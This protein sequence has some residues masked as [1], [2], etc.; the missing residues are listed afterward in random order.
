MQ[1]TRRRV[2]TTDPTVCEFGGIEIELLDAGDPDAPVIVLCHGWPE[3]SH[4]WRHQIE[5]L[6]AAGWRVLV[7]D[8]RGY[9]ASSAPKLVDAY[10]TDRL[11]ADLVALL[12]DVGASQAVFVGHDWGALVVWDLARFHPDRV[13]AVV[14][15][16]VPYTPWMQRPTDQFREQFGDRFFYMLYFQEPDLAER[17]LE[18][19][20]E[21]SLLTILWGGDGS[22][23]RSAPDPS[24]LPPMEGTGLLDAWTGGVR[25]PDGRPPWLLETDLDHY[26]EQF[27][28]S[29]FFGPISWYRNIDADF[30]LT[31]A[32]PA[33]AMPC[34]FIAGSRD[35][36]IQFRPGYVESMEFTLADYRGAT[37][38][39]GPGH[40]VQQEAPAEF[41]VAL[42][43]ALDAVR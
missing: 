25:V 3:S 15:A 39:D 34:A 43:S 19:N 1:I 35:L 21:R 40:W 12:D 33:P 7:P 4:S 11:S 2:A 8:Q 31:K 6:V 37:I 13:S 32:L 28:T 16:S 26:V 20:L 30:E 14:N 29:G 22:I 5:P 27:T 36:V 38:I 24:E 18:A 17:E 10:R 42:L 23:E 41:N 9:G